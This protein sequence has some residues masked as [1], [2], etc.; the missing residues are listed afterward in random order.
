MPQ[1]KRIRR[2]L[3]LQVSEARPANLDERWTRGVRF[4][5]GWSRYFSAVPAY[6]SVQAFEGDPIQLAGY[7]AAKAAWDAHHHAVNWMEITE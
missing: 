2:R 5:H 4:A 6:E 7:L 1:S 3:T